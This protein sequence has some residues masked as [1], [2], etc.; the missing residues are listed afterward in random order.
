MLTQSMKCIPA[1]A[2]F[3]RNN[4][5]LTCRFGRFADTARTVLV[6]LTE[7]PVRTVVQARVTAR[8]IMTAPKTHPQI[9]RGAVPTFCRE[10][11]LSPQLRLTLEAVVIVVETTSLRLLLILRRIKMASNKAVCR[12]QIGTGWEVYP[13]R[14]IPGG[15]VKWSPTA[16]ALVPSRSSS[17][18]VVSSGFST[19]RAISGGRVKCPPTA[20][21]LVPGRRH[22]SR[23]VSSGF[24]NPDRVRCRA[25]CRNR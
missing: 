2:S 16:T 18:N 1:Y 4:N 24:N 10:L 3:R 17:N 14:A 23:V 21:A 13:S 20:T 9:R 12:L 6:S 25:C 5:E 7:A 22:S 11:T 15:R 19:S 8:R